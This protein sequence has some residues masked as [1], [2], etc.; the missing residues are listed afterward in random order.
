[1]KKRTIYILIASA[2]IVIASGS[3]TAWLLLREP[4]VY[5]YT[6][7]NAF[8][9]LSFTNPVGIYD[10]NDE[11]NRLF[12]VEQ[13]G[14]IQVF[15]NDPSASTYS[16]F[17]D[18]SS[19]VT[20]GG[21][22]GLLGL[23]F[24]PN[25]ATNGYFYIYYIDEIN[26]DSVLSRFS[27]NATDM[28]KTDEFSE[29][30]L[31]RIPQPYAN[32]N[33][34]QIAFGPDGYLYI[35]LGDGGNAY[36]PHGNAQNR[37]TLLG[38]I[39]RID[40]DS[41]S[42]YSI[43]EDNPFYGNTDGYKEEIFA[44]GLRNPWR[45]SFDVDSGDLWVGDVGQN[46]IE[47]IDIVKNGMNYGWNTREGTHEINPGTNVTTLVDPIWEYDHSLG[48]SITG[49]FVYRGTELS[50]LEGKY[51]YGDY[52]SGR[53]WALEFSGDTAINNNLLVDTPLNIPSFGV[54]AN[55]ELYICAF[56]GYIY[57]L[58]QNVVES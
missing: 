16:S 23:A 22:Q 39:L 29:V 54:D 56:D 30:E 9:N 15:E 14:D 18:F 19:E 27:V 2:V 50:E 10:A 33:G 51:I 40:V 43:P 41:G 6:V 49:G 25:Y 8:P 3:F 1:M 44:F 13:I 35:A 17:L 42:P 58:V 4:H 55:N 45:F 47:E 21:E 46:Q 52:G 53:V 11:T 5:E 32:H 48:I 7:E 24:H 26:E 20:A 12:V 36:D 34:G 31:L 28:N 57:K 37:S 38:S